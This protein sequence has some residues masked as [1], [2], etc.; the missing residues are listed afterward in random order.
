MP[1]AILFDLDG[2]L[3]HTYEAWF[4]LMNAAARDFG[5]PE[6][7]RERFKA[8]FGQSTE[9]DAI[10]FFGGRALAEVERY[11]VEHFGEHAKGVLVEAEAGRVFEALRAAGRKIAVVTNSPRL[12]AIPVLE[13]A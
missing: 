8:S 2:V 11:F 6:I 5:C 1:A 13:S 10:D 9:Q 12:I 4:S 3:V 7:S